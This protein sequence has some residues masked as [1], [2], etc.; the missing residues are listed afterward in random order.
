VPERGGADEAV[1]GGAEAA[2]GRH[3][4]VALL[5]DFREH[6][7]RVAPVEAHPDVRRVGAAVGGVSHVLEGLFENGGVL[8][9][10]GHQLRHCAH[11]LV[12]EARQS[13]GLRDVGRACG[14]KGFGV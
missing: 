8:L 2:S 13:T 7:P 12:G 5:Q 3:H 4:D 14:V 9:V 11:A 1:A 6:L 10:E